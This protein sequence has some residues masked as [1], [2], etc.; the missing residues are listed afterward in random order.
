MSTCDS[1]LVVTEDKWSILNVVGVGPK[2][3]PGVTG[4]S[5]L[6]KIA[7]DN[8]SALKAVYATSNGTVSHATL[9][10]VAT[11]QVIGIAK[12]SALPASSVQVQPSGQMQDPSWNWIPGQSI[13]LSNNGNLTQTL[14]TTSWHVE[15]AVA[16]ATNSI[17]I[18]I[19]PSIFLI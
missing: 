14:P 1:I 18:N 7:F 5:S 11:T 15:L 3:D 19:Q 4:G 6:T 2:G 16:D 13:Y 12:G 10:T 9:S 8:V 17:I